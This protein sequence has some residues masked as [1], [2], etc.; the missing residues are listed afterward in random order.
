MKNHN[1]KKRLGAEIKWSCRSSAST[2][3]TS[4]LCIR[5]CKKQELTAPKKNKLLQSNSKKNKKRYNEM[6]A[7]GILFLLIITFFPQYGYCETVYIKNKIAKVRKENNNKSPVIALLKRGDNVDIKKVKDCWPQVYIK[8]RKITGWI[9]AT[10]VTYKKQDKKKKVAY[11]KKE[12]D[13]LF[14]K[15]E[16]GNLAISIDEPAAGGSIRAGKET[17]QAKPEKDKQKFKKVISQCIK[18]HGKEVN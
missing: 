2:E 8:K 1:G 7:W 18:K 16:N 4:T 6:L 11:E 12:A 3:K 17:S 13:D 14:A 10:E 15:L 9:Y 5:R